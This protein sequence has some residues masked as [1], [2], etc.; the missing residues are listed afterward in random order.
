MSNEILQEFFVGNSVHYIEEIISVACSIRF[1][2]PFRYE[3]D[4]CSFIPVAVIACIEN[5]NIVIYACHGHDTKVWVARG[6]GG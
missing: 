5:K 1:K 2:D 6:G 3:K 4:C